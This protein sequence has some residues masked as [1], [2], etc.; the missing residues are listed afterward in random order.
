MASPTPAVER[1]NAGLDAAKRMERFYRLYYK[2]RQL[3]KRCF[4]SNPGFFLKILGQF[5]G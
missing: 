5:S 3:A 2:R 4:S 1:S